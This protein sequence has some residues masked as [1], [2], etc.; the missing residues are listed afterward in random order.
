ME[1]VVLMV[2]QCIA[3]HCWLPPRCKKEKGQSLPEYGLILALVTI[4]CIG[5]VQL[6]GNQIQGVITSF[7]AQMN[8][9]NGVAAA[10]AA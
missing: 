1:R 10:G 7:T 4:F 5:A 9:V 2:K 6:L 3:F 8:G